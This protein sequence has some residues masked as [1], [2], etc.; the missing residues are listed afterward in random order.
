MTVPPA[1]QCT[2]PHCEREAVDPTQRVSLCDSHQDAVASDEPITSSEKST[3]SDAAP[4]TSPDTDTSLGE[5]VDTVPAPLDELGEAFIPFDPGEKGA[6]RPRTPEN[7][8]SP[9][10][11]VLEAYL[12]VGHNYGVVTRGDLAVVDADE[13]DRLDGLLDALPETAWQ[14]SGSRT[15]EHW[16]IYVPGL[17]E[18]IP[19]IDP[20]TEDELGHVK[21][22]EQSYV[23]GP[24]SLHPSGNRYGPLQGDT[25]APVD[26]DELRELIEPYRPATPAKRD[27]DTVDWDA[28]DGD[29]GDGTDLSV[30]DVVSRRR[31]PEGERCEHP[32]HGSDTGANFMVDEGGD[33][34]R[35]WRHDC[36]GNA[37]HL[38]GVE[39]GVISCGDWNHTG[40]ET[41]TW[42]EIFEAAREAGYDLP[43]YERPDGDDVEHTAVMLGSPRRRAAVNGWDW[44]ADDR[45]GLTLDEVRDRTVDAIVDAIEGRTDTLLEALPGS[46]KT[47][48][49][50]IATEQTGEKATIAVPRGN[51]EMYGAV[52]TEAEQRGLSAKVLPRVFG[53]DDGNG[54]C[55]T[56]TGEHGESWKNSFERWYFGGNATGQEIHSYAAENGIEL[57]CQEDGECPHTAA[58]R[59]DPDDY[60]VLVGHYNHLHNDSVTKGRV[61]FVDEYPDDYEQ[62]ITDPAQS[63]SHFLASTDELPFD[64]YTDLLERRTEPEPRADALAWF[65]DNLGRDG[66]Q[67]FDDDGDALAPL[68][69]FTILAGE[70][71]GNEFERA[72]FPAACDDAHLGL[73]DRED[74]VVHLLMPPTTPYARNVIALDGTPTPR[75]WDITLGRRLEHT[76]VLSD[77]EK[78]RYVTEAL[79]VNVVRTTDAVKSYATNEENIEQRVTVDEDRTLFEAI[80]N[81]HGERPELLTTKRAKDVYDEAGA[82]DDV[83]GVRWHG[84]VHGSNEL[85]DCRLGV[86]AGARNFGPKWVKRWGAYLGETV[87]PRYP[88]EDIPL[89]AGVTTDYGETGNDLAEHM[90]VAQT[91]QAIFRF[92]RDGNGAVVYVHTNTLPDWMPASDD[93]RVVRTRADG[94]REVI[95]A[96]QALGREFTT[97]DVAAEV[98]ISERQV[99]THLHRLADRDAL[100]V[101][102]E[103]CGFVWR[104]DGLH[105]LNEHGEVELEPVDL[106]ELTDEESAEVARMEYYWWNFRTS[107]LSL[108]VRGPGA[109]AS[110]STADYL[111][112][113]GGDPP[114]HDAD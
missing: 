107:G 70:S 102:I 39:Q 63:V 98:S 101:E 24:G 2:L 74:G 86:V 71:L 44:T 26:E 104:D 23:V 13:P 42:R 64:D 18:D 9:A 55:P 5:P 11:P 35:C 38:V 10:D 105:R 12:D 37:L 28:L 1:R 62:A 19:L 31:Y 77:E 82:L 111:T 110:G 53:D 36:T 72:R 32:L 22:A 3:D 113:N 17:D 40:L 51:N 45:D 106:D 88:G 92:G 100:D 112:G 54:G 97:A 93:A 114:P 21:G 29:G 95:A 79:G 43:D 109:A 91:T 73:F 7:L 66:R 14:V 20:E 27:R 65:T 25:I 76:E 41:D 84:D 69:T 52:K 90:T 48:G 34:W 96:A 57:P 75:L 8:L 47:T 58:W 56:A 68:A 59:F 89:E 33:T 78:T 99:R 80:A 85:A 83:A 81:E 60:D 61:T 87:E 46:G 6:R 30:H 4:E 50:L 15:S 16:F 94:E 103:G 49:A 108:S 67:A